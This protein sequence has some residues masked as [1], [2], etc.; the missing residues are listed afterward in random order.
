M[1]SHLNTTKEYI[2]ITYTM[3]NIEQ[4][5]FPIYKYP[6]KFKLMRA[7]FERINYRNNPYGLIEFKVL[8]PKFK[9]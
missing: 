5:P 6:F 7:I 8:V 9:I 2:Q 1:Y 3:R 4:I